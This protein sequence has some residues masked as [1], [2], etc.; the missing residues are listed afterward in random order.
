M[1]GFI[2]NPSTTIFYPLTPK[3]CFV[4]CSMLERMVVLKGEK[5]PY[6]KQDFLK[7]EKG[8]AYYMNFEF[9]KSANT[10]LILATT[11][12]NTA[13]N[14]LSLDVLGNYPQIPFLLSSATNDYESLEKQQALTNF[15]RLVDGIFYPSYRKY[16][17]KPFYGIEFSMGRNPFSIFGVTDDRLPELKDNLN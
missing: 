2:E 3:K 10:S 8:D 5:I 17:F 1:T 16:P 15:M 14:A 13:I 7:L 6:P 4:A 12:D 9:I 11:D